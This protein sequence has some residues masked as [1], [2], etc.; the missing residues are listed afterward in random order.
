MVFEELMRVLEH[1]RPLLLM[2]L[3]LA[4]GT[5]CA[6]LTQT[7]LA[8]GL[9]PESYG[10]LSS[11]LVV[12]NLLVPIASMGIPDYWLKY[13]AQYGWK[14]VQVFKGSIYLSLISVTFA[15]SIAIFVS[16]TIINDE[17]SR[18]TIIMVL[19]I[20]LSQAIIS[21]VCSKYK[22][23]NDFLRFSIWNSAT[24][25]VRFVF[26]AISYYLLTSYLE[27][28]L[29]S[30]SSTYSIIS[31]ILAILGSL[32]L[33]DMSKNKF[34]LYGHGDIPVSL[35]IDNVKVKEV[36]KSSWLFSASSFLYIIYYQSDIIL[37]SKLDSP[38][39]TGY[40]NAA[41]VFISATYII[42]SLIVQKYMLPTLHRLFHSGQNSFLK[43]SEKMFY[44]LLALSILLCV[45][46]ILS[47]E[48][49]IILSFGSDY[50]NSITYLTILSCTI[51]L[52]FITVLAGAILT[53]SE[54]MG[55]K[56][57]LMLYAAIFNILSNL[58]FIPIYGGYAAA[59]TT[60]LTELLLLLFF[61]YY[62]LK[63]MNKF[64]NE[65]LHAS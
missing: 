32:I 65:K 20:I 53:A 10:I 17:L 43:Y 55:R 50:R 15:I 2:T 41:F 35:T 37:I 44:I 21:L 63:S 52:K 23:E 36:L 34:R 26:I 11:A 51:P 12:I 13:Y 62:V 25:I 5:V 30:V 58:I 27:F 4:L 18:N 40:Y 38:I 33:I 48:L 7:I 56:V 39:A 57:K 59:V 19:P 29:F 42:P 22:L 60:V 54:F 3:G 61:S 16:V 1:A 49:I 31:I 14:G 46:L 6:F 9:G 24:N 64:K 45:F 8:K 28:D 47:S